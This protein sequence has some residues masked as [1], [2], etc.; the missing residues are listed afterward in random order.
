M[1][2]ETLD[3]DDR[4]YVI[5]YLL[6]AIKALGKYVCVRRPTHRYIYIYIYAVYIVY[7]VCMYTRI[8]KNKELKVKK[9]TGLLL[10]Q[11]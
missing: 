1:D 7:I 5:N 11:Q 9:C 4:C 10:A 8:H 6:Q 3:V 2:V